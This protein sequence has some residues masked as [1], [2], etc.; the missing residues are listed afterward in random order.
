MLEKKIEKKL[1]EEVEKIG[2][3]CVKLVSQN[4]NGI[5]DRLVILP[6]GRVYFIELKKTNGVLSKVQKYQQT[7]LRKLNQKVKT[8]WTLEEVEEFI[9]EVQST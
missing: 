7:R 9:S 1:K 3:L 6:D 4:Q 5:P 8:I 2:G